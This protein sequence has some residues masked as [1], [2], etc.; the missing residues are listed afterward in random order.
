MRR[1][2]SSIIV[3]SDAF[4]D[5]PLS[6]Q[7]LYFH[8]CMNADDDGFVNPK[9]IMRLIGATD[10]ELKILLTK[11]FVLSFE[12]GVIVIKHWLI[13]NSIRKDRYNETQ[14]VDEKKN[15]FIKANKAY[16]DVEQPNGNQMA[17]IGHTQGKLS[18]DK[19]SKVNTNMSA[20]A[21]DTFSKFWKHYPKKELRKKSEDIWKRK[22]LNLHL[23]VILSFIKS[24]SETDRWKKGFIKQPPAF[25]NGECWNDDISTYNDFKQAEEKKNIIIRNSDFT[26][27]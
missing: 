6:T 9:K 26:N 17:T 21:D 22:K 1:L 10:D 8:L 25:L 2:F 12:N 4:L 23:E 16:S 15:L 7:A 11:R 24:A 13:H 27:K 5:M 14:Y 3:E 20:K 19:L 18:K